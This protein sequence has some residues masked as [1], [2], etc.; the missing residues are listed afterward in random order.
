VAAGRAKLPMAMKTL[1]TKSAFTLVELLAVILVLVFLAAW[2]IPAI[3]DRRPRRTSITACMSNQRQIALG[4]TMW[5]DDHDGQF[6][7][8]VSITNGN[9]I[10]YA[11]R[12]AASDFQVLSNY[13]TRP[14]V[15]VCPTDKARVVAVDFTQFDN[16]NVSYLVSH[17]LGADNN[18]GILTGDR[19]LENNGKPINPGLFTYS[20]GCVL[21]WTRELH[22]EVKNGPIGVLSFMDG[23]AEAI[24]NKNL[25]SAFQRGGLG[26]NRYVVP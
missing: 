20:K 1:S 16:R 10:E 8:Q 15:F 23:H 5:K 19:H 2:L 3:S 26:T 11:L 4:L 18:V 9:V 13:L 14:T 25:N 21:D 17:D 7:W 6:P 12:D 24:Q 22:G